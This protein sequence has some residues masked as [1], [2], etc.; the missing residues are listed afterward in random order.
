MSSQRHPLALSF[1]GAALAISLS[2]CATT[3]E[4]ST[5]QVDNAS[6]TSAES[7]STSMEAN[8]DPALALELQ[9][10]EYALR[11]LERAQARWPWLSTDETCIVL[12]RLT[13]QYLF[14]C[15]PSEGSPF[16]PTGA[17]F[18]GRSVY[19]NGTELAA[20]GPQRAPH[21][22]VVQS[23]VGTV[24]LYHPA[25]EALTSFAKERPYIFITSLDALSEAHPAFSSSS[26]TEEWLSIFVHEYFHTRQF[27]HERANAL[28][29]NMLQQKVGPGPLIARTPPT[30]SPTSPSTSRA[31]RA[32]PRSPARATT[33]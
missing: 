7:A 24:L 15:E 23:I 20:V 19:R 17:T 12:N 6:A 30:T 1:V 25:N 27:L 5:A 9:R 29:G 11:S 10:L 31:S 21:S 3:Q 33:G 26:T 32:S 2:A 16:E 14:M 18:R 13:E 22:V 4:A 8:I 28:W